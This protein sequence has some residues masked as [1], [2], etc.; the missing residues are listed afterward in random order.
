[1]KNKLVIKK[2]SMKSL[3]SSFAGK[4]LPPSIWN[5]KVLYLPA[6]LAAAHKDFLTDKG[7][8]NAYQPGQGGGTG[9][10]LTQ[11]A[12]EHV[13]NRFLNSAARMQFVC[14]D[15]RDEEPEVRD[16]V[17]DQLGDGHIYL[18][19]LAAGN[20]A[21]TLAM[22]SLLCE[23]RAQ[24]SVPKLPLNVSIVGVDFSADALNFYAELLGKIPPWFETNGIN[25][26]LNLVVCDLTVSGDFSEELESFFDDAKKQDVKRFLCVISAL[27]GAGKEGFEE[28]HDSLKIVA[29]RLSSTKR[30]SSWLWVEPPVKKFWITMFADT[31]RLTLKKVRHKFFKSNDFYSIKTDV[32]LFANPVVRNFDWHDPHN[33]TTTESNV[34]VMA[35]KSE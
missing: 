9:G 31:V 13:I 19:D 35:F 25:I 5:S 11:E 16:M 28:M 34:F 1:M 4:N 29:A 2:M 15:P 6:Q 27:S 26:T 14:S 3:L 32:P 7:W 20:G 18:L 23:L 17:L 33:E 12:Q 30:N 24:K 8:L 10:R 21:G 22:L